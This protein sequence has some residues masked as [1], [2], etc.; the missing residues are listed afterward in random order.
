M[1]NVWSDNCIRG[2]K[3]EVTHVGRNGLWKLQGREMEPS[4]AEC[5]VCMVGTGDFDTT[6]ENSD[7]TM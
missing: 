7:S 1:K 5:R 2:P 6:E 3:K 4:F